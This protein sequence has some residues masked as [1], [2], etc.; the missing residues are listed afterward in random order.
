[1]TQEQRE[2]HPTL[3]SVRDLLLSVVSCQD[4]KA[5]YMLECDPAGFNIAVSV[6]V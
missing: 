3:R 1:M 5:I 4:S 6:S 2:E